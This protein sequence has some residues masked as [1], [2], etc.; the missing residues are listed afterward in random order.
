MIQLLLSLIKPVSA[1]TLQ[2]GLCFL[3]V[4]IGMLMIGHGFPKIIGGPENWHGLGQIMNL[5]GIYFLPT[6]WGFFAACAE[7]FGG[8]ALTLG[9]G[10]RI[11]SF[12]LIIQMIVALVFH[13]SKRDSF[14]I[15][16]H[17]LALLVVFITFMIIG[18]GKFSLDEYF[19][20]LRRTLG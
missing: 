18:G 1:D 14:M 10:T 11:A 7:F 17:A 13:L 6:M 3:R 20:T 2:F 19:Y 5:L 8:I 16:S 15:Y 9:L 4:C 12:F